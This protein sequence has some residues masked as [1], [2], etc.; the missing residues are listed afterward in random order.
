[1][2]TPKKIAVPAA[3]GFV[4]SFVIS[5]FFHTQPPKPRGGG[6]QGVNFFPR[7]GKKTPLF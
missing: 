5:L 6:P 7:G 1:M 3:A 2:L 4:I